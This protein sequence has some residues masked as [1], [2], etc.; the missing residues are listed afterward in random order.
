MSARRVVV[1][2]DGTP[3]SV[4][5]LDWATVEAE[6][7]GV[8]LHIGFADPYVAQTLHAYP[9]DFG[10]ESL[11]FGR[12][13]LGQAAQRARRVLPEERVTTEAVIS[14]PAAFLIELSYDADLVVTGSRGRGAI[15]AGLLGS[16]AYAVAAHASCPVVIV[17][18]DTLAPVPGRPIIVGVDRSRASDRAV[19]LAA[20]LAG[21]QGV[22]LRLVTVTAQPSAE[23]WTN[24][25]AVARDLLQDQQRMADRMLEE[26]RARV[27]GAYPGLAVEVAVLQGDPGDALAHEGRGASL[28]VVGSRGRGGFAGMLLGSISHRVVHAATCPVMVVRE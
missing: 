25:G 27:L 23:A 21:D 12:E 20:S 9:R 28:L 24:Y 1:G 8:G 14:S 13:A 16:V 26:T 11:T 6:R 15:A 10:E 2:Y 3:E 22:L 7:R 17:R 4:T 5:A 18:G 19:D